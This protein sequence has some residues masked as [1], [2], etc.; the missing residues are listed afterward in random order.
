M[1]VADVMVQ[2]RRNGVVVHHAA[3]MPVPADGTASIVVFLEGTL[4]QFELARQLALRLRGVS[5][6]TFAGFSNAI[7]YVYCA[8]PHGRDGP[9]PPPASGGT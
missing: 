1:D 2:L 7:M 9:I 5:R 4:G 6:V 8:P 3:R